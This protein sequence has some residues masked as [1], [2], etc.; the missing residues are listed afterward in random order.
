MLRLSRSDCA[1]SEI[2]VD[3]VLPSSS[4]FSAISGIIA[5]SGAIFFEASIILSALYTTLPSLSM[6]KNS[7]SNPNVDF[8]A[9]IQK[10]S[11]TVFYCFWSQH[12]SL[13]NL[14]EATFLLMPSLISPTQVKLT[15]FAG[16]LRFAWQLR[17]VRQGKRAK[18]RKLTSPQ[19]IALSS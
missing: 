11:F 7:T 5:A 9:I 16:C 17:G 2:F 12:T 8:T 1:D 14:N 4:M 3:G 10:R 6:R 19:Q 13:R 15:S 18:T